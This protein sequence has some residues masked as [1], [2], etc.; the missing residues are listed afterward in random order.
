[1]QYACPGAQ[2]NVYCDGVYVGDGPL[3]PAGVDAAQLRQAGLG[4]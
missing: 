1:M 3:G 4:Q 2:Y